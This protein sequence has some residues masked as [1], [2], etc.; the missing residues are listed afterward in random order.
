MQREEQGRSRRERSTA[1]LAPLRRALCRPTRT[2][3]PSRPAAATYEGLRATSHPPVLGL[4]HAVQNALAFLV[5]GWAPAGRSWPS[6]GCSPS[7]ESSRAG[8]SSRRRSAG[9]V[10]PS[11]QH[12]RRRRVGLRPQSSPETQALA[13]RRRP[14]RL[15]LVEPG[16]P[17]QRAGTSMWIPTTAQAFY[18]ARKQARH[19]RRA[20]EA[21]RRRPPAEAWI[22]R[23]K[24]LQAPRLAFLTTASAG[25]TLQ[26]HQVADQESPRASGRGAPHC[27][28]RPKAPPC[29]SDRDW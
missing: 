29:L 17:A 18:R 6:P 16:E 14:R 3:F 7:Q 5:L 12:R 21:T 1:C 20:L 19:R 22:A 25:Q 13:T 24:Q 11:A 9:A 27:R 10:I 2:G 4:R 23:A 15:R 8:Q 28:R 26:E